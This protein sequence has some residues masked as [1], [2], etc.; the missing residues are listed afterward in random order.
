M[1]DANQLD[2]TSRG[3]PFGEKATVFW[4]GEGIA[5]LCKIK[6][7]TVIAESTPRASVS[8]ARRSRVTA[9][10]GLAA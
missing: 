5:C 1:I 3:N 8:N 4:A 9:A 7:G 6:V 10:P 2:I